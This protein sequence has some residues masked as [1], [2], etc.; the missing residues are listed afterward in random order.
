MLS[1]GPFQ[2]LS[3]LARRIGA[4]INSPPPARLRRTTS[5]KR[6][7]TL[8]PECGWLMFHPPRNGTL[9]CAQCGWK[10]EWPP[11]SEEELARRRAEREKRRADRR[12]RRRTP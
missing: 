3:D 11:P 2:F 7:P 8:C 6:R 10:T 4:W 5:P 9:F 1:S 12:R